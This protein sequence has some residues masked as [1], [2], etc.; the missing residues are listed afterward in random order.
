MKTA[1]TSIE[2]FGTPHFQITWESTLK[3]NLDCSYCSPNDH[4]NK[5]PHPTLE[6]CLKTVDFFLEYTDVYMQYKNP[7]QRNVGFNVFGGES[8]FHPNIIE[9]LIYIKEQH[10]K[11]QDKWTMTVQ[12]V[13][14]AVVKEKIWQKA[15]PLI[16]Y[17]T[18]SYH[19]EATQ[20]Q[21][22]LLKENLLVLKKHNKRFVC[23]ILMH[24]GRWDNCQSMIAWCKQHDIPYL[25]RQLDHSWHD[26]KYFYDSDQT[27]WWDNER[28]INSKVPL[29]KKIINIVN[30][31]SQGRSCCGSNPLSVNG[32][33][34][35]SQTYIPGNNFKGWSCSVNYFFVYVKQVTKEIF[36][37]KDCQMNFDGKVAPIGTIDNHKEIIKQLQTN[38]KNGTMPV[39]VC[40]KSKCWCGLCAPKA[41][42]RETFDTMMKK[43]VADSV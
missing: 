2:P 5:I 16:D 3:C 13:T 24:A 18:V 38:L 25:P 31:D 19:S 37:N 9:I 28:G 6:D 26:F 8:F 11:Y 39:V 12:T 30:L 32:D 42:D 34:S 29:Y 14:N 23:S 7:E 43:Y 4:N 33:T 36:L 27:E 35:C 40:N 41:H 1:Y 15:L 21:Q 20:D 22:A 10:K 17:Y